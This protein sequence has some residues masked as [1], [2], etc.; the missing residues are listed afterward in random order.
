MINLGDKNWG[1]K[2]SGLLA[3]KQVGSRFFNKDF[4]FTRASNGTYV[5][6]DGVLQ[7]AELYNLINYSQ[8]LNSNTLSR[9]SVSD[10]DILSPFNNNEKSLFIPDTLNNFHYPRF[11]AST[12]SGFV[13]TISVFLKADGSDAF[14]FVLVNISFGNSDGNAGVIFNIK[15]AEKVG[16]FTH[17]YDVQ[18][19]DFGNGWHRYSFQFTTS[20]TSV[21][22]DCNVLPSN[23]AT[24]YSG[25]GINGA[26]IYG[27][28]L[29]EGT[30]PL[31]YQYT[32]GRV[33]I[34]RIDFSDGVGALLLEPQSTNIVTYSEDYS[35]STV[36]VK[37]GNTS[38]NLNS[39]I[40]PD[41]TQNASRISGLDGSGSNDLRYFPSGFN[42]ANKTLTFSAYLKGSGTLRMQISNGV[43][44]GPSQTITLT[45]DWKRHSLTATFNST[46]SSGF[47]INFDDLD[48]ATATSYDLYGVQ[49]EEKSYATSLI[50]TSGSAVTRIADVANNCGSEQDFN[51]EEGVLYFETKS[52]LPNGEDRRIS[53]SDGTLNNRIEFSYGNGNNQ[54]FCIVTLNSVSVIYNVS[55]NLSNL[56]EYKKFAIKYK[57]G[58]SKFYIDGNE[59]ISSTAPYTY[60]NSIDNLQLSNSTLNGVLDFY[61]KVRSVK[62]FP[63]ALTDEQLENLTT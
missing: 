41:G 21:S 50:N 32:N 14:N 56:D 25:D 34:P 29:V 35:K 57:S 45:S 24:S 42:S 5:D 30:E 28:Q 15:D 44:Q 27:A 4:D 22:V 7:T 36:W 43:N 60:T 33:G 52:F 3:Y 17:D 26:Y 16:F 37:T 19:D 11:S 12:R 40:S 20:Q 31:D 13:H 59:V 1:V 39:I 51:S 8:D 49:L 48:G 62:Y 55:L 2:D 54:I 10:A 63:E 46:T 47:H 58:D 23:S 18:I 61:G 53:I 9:G 6:K 38:I